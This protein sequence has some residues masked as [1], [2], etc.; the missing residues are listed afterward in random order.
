MS[1]PAP[2]NPRRG[3][4]VA[5]ILFLA[6]AWRLLDIR[7]HPWSPDQQF[8]VDLASGTWG[9][10]LARTTADVHPPLYYA[11]VKVWY[12]FTP[13]TLD[14][15]QVFSV[16]ISTATLYLIWKLAT[17]EWGERAGWI[18]LVCA[19]FAPYAVFWGHMARNHQLLPL[20]VVWALLARSRFLA[21]SSRAQ[22]WSSAAA[23]A[24]AMQTNYMGGVFVALWLASIL[25]EYRVP[26]RERFTFAGSAA[27]GA[28]LF[29]PWVPI[30]L[31]HT[32]SSNV[33]A[34]FF[35]EQVSPIYFYY[36]ALFGDMVAYQPNQEGLLFIVCL[37]IF[38]IPSAI[39]LTT[40][41]GK[42]GLAFLLVAMPLVPIAMVS[43]GGWTLAERHLLFALPLFYA[44]WGSAVD[45][46]IRKFRRAP[47]TP[48]E[49]A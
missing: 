1:E 11:L 21:N 30:L 10:L 36:H 46:S 26:L 7:L 12:I 29:A 5:V 23:L 34:G 28:I 19:A 4:I 18:A 27:P 20:A 14:S 22:W 33:N 35:Q 49:A 8:T 41:Q 39:G 42:P 3:P 47:S 6:A 43:V 25:I 38:A 16:L 2:P 15:A 48:T 45:A 24:F 40:F 17:T 37:L 9:E 44:W 32:A 13:D 31:E